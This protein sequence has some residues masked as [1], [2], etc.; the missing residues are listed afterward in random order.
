MILFNY[1]KAEGV[2]CDI[3]QWLHVFVVELFYCV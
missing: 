2:I 3:N 1:V